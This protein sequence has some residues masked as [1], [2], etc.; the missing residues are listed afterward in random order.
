MDAGFVKAEITNLPKI[1]A[2]MI[3]KF[4]EYL[5]FAECRNIKTTLKV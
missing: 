5:F 3:A 2:V 1:D 4:F